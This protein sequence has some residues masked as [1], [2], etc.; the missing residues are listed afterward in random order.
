M[1]LMDLPKLCNNVKA[2]AH[3]SLTRARAKTPKIYKLYFCIQK[4]LVVF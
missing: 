1:S 2:Q 3:V 4:A